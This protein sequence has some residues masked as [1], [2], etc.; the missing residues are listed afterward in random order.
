MSDHWNLLLDQRNCAR[1]CDAESHREVMPFM[2]TGRSMAEGVG[3]LDASGSRQT[4]RSPA[5]QGGRATGV[6]PAASRTTS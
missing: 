4:S 5:T 1:S 6:E 2:F 3:K